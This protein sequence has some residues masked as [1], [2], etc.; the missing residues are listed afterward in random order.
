MHQAIK[1]Y[2]DEAMSRRNAIAQQM[3]TVRDNETLITGFFQLAGGK[4]DTVDAYA[5]YTSITVAAF[6]ASDN[7]TL[8][9]TI[10]RISNFLGVDP[11]SQDN[12]TS[13]VRTFLWCVDGYEFHLHAVLRAAAGCVVAQVGTKR[14]K[15]LRYVEEET[16]IFQFTC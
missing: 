11:T 10:T 4:G 8:A 5:A 7:P 3:C 2:L 12:P 1:S 13:G 9:N 14:Q 16:P 6:T 15:V